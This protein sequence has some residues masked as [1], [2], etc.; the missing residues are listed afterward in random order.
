MQTNIERSV[1]RRFHRIASVQRQLVVSRCADMALRHADPQSWVRDVFATVAVRLEATDVDAKIIKEARDQVSLIAAQ[2]LL[3]VT[4]QCDAAGRGGFTR[5]AATRSVALHKRPR[6][7]AS[8]DS[9]VTT[10]TSC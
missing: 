9:K 8:S 1:H 6:H 2:L 4:V 7:R 3:E 10:P 5:L